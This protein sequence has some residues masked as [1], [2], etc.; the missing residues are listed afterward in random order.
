MKILGV[1]LG[2]ASVG[3]AL[4]DTE[5]EEIIASG[6]RIFSESARQGATLASIRRLHRSVRRTLSRK[7]QRIK[8]IKQLVT[9]YKLLKRKKIDFLHRRQRR[10]DVWQLR[11]EALHRELNIEEWIRILLHIAKR[12]G[13]KSNRKS[14]QKSSDIETKKMLKAI[15]DNKQKISKDG[16]ETVGSMIYNESKKDSHSNHTTHLHNRILRAKRNK[17]DNYIL[18][19]SREMLQEEIEI[20][21]KKQ[22][23][24]CSPKF[25]EK[26]KKIA[27]SQLPI[28]W[29]KNMV[30]KCRF[31]TKEPRGPKH[32]FS[33]EKSV[34]LSKINNTELFDKN[35]GEIKPLFEYGLDTLLNIF[36]GTKEVKYSTLR[37]RLE[38]P[39]NYEFKQLD[40]NQN[41]ERKTN[42][43]T[44]IGKFYKKE[45]WLNEKQKKTFEERCL[46][47]K[48]KLKNYKYSSVRNILQLDDNQ[49]FEDVEYDQNIEKKEL[50]GKLEGYHKIKKALSQEVFNTI[51]SDLDK[52]NKTAEILS[53]EKEDDKIREKL[54]EQVFKELD[55]DKENKKQA[56]EKLLEISFSG[57]NNL[58]VK[59]INKLLPYLE[60]GKKYHEAADLSPKN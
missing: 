23:H 54:Q 31:E 36:F 39:N 16:Y 53:Y 57:F 44:D 22:K 50:F 19:A 7:K 28:R 20:L 56:I 37:N 42:I 58:S 38:I 49:K 52:F 8:A 43:G 26:Y 2:I 33:V 40:Y 5:K 30:G 55:I 4:V 41:F 60:S 51:F 21:Y 11:E 15:E 27:F 17:K 1:D 24:L 47:E 18:S 14:E 25:M 46:T 45:T 13:Y 48:G 6:V 9:E 34:L 10:K 12:R 35:T 29:D 59:A 3:W 32:C